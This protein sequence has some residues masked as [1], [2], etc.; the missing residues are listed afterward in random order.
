VTNPLAVLRTRAA[1]GLR[2]ATVPALIYV[3]LGALL[4]PNGLGILS[5][6]ILGHLD[7]VVSIALATL[8]VFVGIAL[9]RHVR[10]AGRLLAAAS[11]EAG[12]TLLVV[13]AAATVLLQIWNMPLDAAPVA[14]ALALG[15]CGA[16]S[17]ASAHSE[18]PE[19][20]TAARI[21]DLDD[22]LPILLGGGVLVLMRQPD[23]PH[24]ALMTLVTMAVGVAVGAVGWLLFDVANPVER[25]GLVF[26]ALALLAGSA[27]YLGLSP[28]LAGVSAGLFWKL[29]PGRADA[30]MDD[31][32]RAEHPLVVLLLLTAGAAMTPNLMAL[33]LFA[34][35]V[36]FRLFGKLAGGWAAA[37]MA[38]GFAHSILSAQLAHPGVLG[39][40]FA[41]NV[42]QVA[43]SATSA[44]ILTA[45]AM[46][47]LVSEFIAILV[48]PLPP[49]V[50]ARVQATPAEHR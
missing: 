12:I 47:A 5:V 16:V 25:G 43:P 33:W 26:G 14:V 19:A 44:A 37:R 45:V 15:V 4:G 10:G 22:I 6:E 11:I 39:L 41:L 2:P 24:A 21:A 3:P 48:A 38:G 29:A 8:G 42:Q 40:A 46:G 30:I 23:V 34:P 35:Y 20:G 36:T 9:G 27:A 18:D 1:L 13:A 7:A 17:G 31:L 49:A 32:R 28:L 50:P